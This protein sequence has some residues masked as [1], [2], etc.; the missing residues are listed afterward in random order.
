VAP[1]RFAY[2]TDNASPA[3]RD[4]FSGYSADMSESDEIPIADA[5]EQQQEIGSTVPDDE[6]PADEAADVPLEAPDADWQEQRQEVI[7]GAEEAPA[8]EAADVPLEA[9][10][11]DWQEQRQEVV[12]DAEEPPNG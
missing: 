10:D 1:K 6:A 7:D 4:H 3:F 11:A 2:R 12:D 5:L 9:P 8:D